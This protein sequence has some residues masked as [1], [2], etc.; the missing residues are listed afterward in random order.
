MGQE[1]SLA[2]D[3]A[4]AWM[5]HRTVIL[6]SFDAYLASEDK[7]R[8]ERA[9]QQSARNQRLVCFPFALMLQ[10]SFAELDFANRWCWT[11]FGPANGECAQ[12]D[13]EYRVC[14]IDKPHSHSGVWMTHWFVK[15]DYNFGFN[16]WYFV[17][18]ARHDLFLAFVPKINWGENYPH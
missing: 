12:M 11:R 8:E 1:H 4:W 5:N 13:S 16:E 10:V 9:S 14:Q 7:S 17:D 18:Q 3:A 15:T 6:S 2:A